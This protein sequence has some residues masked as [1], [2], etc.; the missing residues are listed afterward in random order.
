[1]PLDEKPFARQMTLEFLNQGTIFSIPDSRR[2][3]EKGLGR[4]GPV[5][6]NSPVVTDLKESSP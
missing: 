3:S 5:A 1:M 4:L 2:Q 6:F